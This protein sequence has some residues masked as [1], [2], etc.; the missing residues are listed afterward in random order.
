MSIKVHIS[1]NKKEIYKVCTFISNRVYNAWVGL[2]CFITVIVVIIVNWVLSGF[3][4]YNL[5]LLSIFI[6][7]L[8]IFY[9]LYYRRLKEGYWDFYK[10]KKGGSYFFSDDGIVICG[11]EIKSECTWNVFKRA[12]IIPNFFL[13]FDE[14]KFMYV[15]PHRC[16]DPSEIS[17]FKELI[18]LKIKKVKEYK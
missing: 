7:A 13:L 4:N 3:S 9:Y 8:F 14:N 12:I 16:F 5:G 15:F 2:I 18:M 11:E 1:Y 17:I 10:M 6:I